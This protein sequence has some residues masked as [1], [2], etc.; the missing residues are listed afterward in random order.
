MCSRLIYR[1]IVLPLILQSDTCVH[2]C[3]FISS[4]GHIIQLEVPSIPC[5]NPSGKQMSVMPCLLVLYFNFNSVTET[6]P[7]TT[8]FNFRFL[9]DGSPHKNLLHPG[10]LSHGFTVSKWIKFIHPLKLKVFRSGPSKVVWQPCSQELSYWIKYHL[11]TDMHQ[12]E[13]LKYLWNI[14]RTV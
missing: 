10:V 3:S 14:Q 1:W 8:Q 13:I 11:A 6:L 4:A 5:K 2:I 12:I 7:T 9:F